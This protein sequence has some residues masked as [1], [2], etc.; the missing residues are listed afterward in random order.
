MRNIDPYDSR[1]PSEYYEIGTIY[2]FY[3]S[4]NMGNFHPA[5]AKYIS[6]YSSA[7]LKLQEAEKTSAIQPVKTSSFQS[8]SVPLQRFYGIVIDKPYKNVIRIMFINVHNGIRNFFT[9]DYTVSYVGC[10][11]DGK[12]LMPVSSSVKC[13]KDSVSKDTKNIGGITRAKSS[14]DVGGITRVKQNDSVA[15]GIGGI[16]RTNKTGRFASNDQPSSSSASKNVG[17]ITRVKN[18]GGITRV[19]K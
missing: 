14:S 17:G 19:K 5:D 6:K 16:T 3:A 2:S 1:Y 10:S 7:L 11:S 9:K 15:S 8:S 13:N 18:V 12:N 4:P